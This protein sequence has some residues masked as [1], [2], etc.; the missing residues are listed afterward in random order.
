MKLLHLLAL[1]APLLAKAQ[2]PIEFSGDVEDVDVE[3]LDVEEDFEDGVLRDLKGGGGGGKS[4]KGTK[5]KDKKPDKGI[6]PQFSMGCQEVTFITKAKDFEGQ[7]RNSTIAFGS[8][9]LYQ[10]VKKGKGTKEVGTYTAYNNGAGVITGMMTF[11]KNT[12]IAFTG[13]QGINIA[14]IVGGTGKVAGAKGILR[15]SSINGGKKQKL[16]AT[17]CTDV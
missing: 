6:G 12:G 9:P 10:K 1:L 13:P 11:N 3:N 2:S 15:V 8:A 16:E 4:S 7:E 14:P 17:I 5:K